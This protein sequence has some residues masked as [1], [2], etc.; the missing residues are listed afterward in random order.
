MKLRIIAAAVAMAGCIFTANA[1]E[2]LGNDIWMGVSGGALSTYTDHFNA[3]QMYFSI[4]AGKYFT[5]VW[6][7][8]IAVGGPF[9]MFD[10]NNKG[11][12]A[13]QNSKNWGKKQV[14]GELSLDGIVNL[15]QAFSKKSLPLVDFYL[16]AGPTATLS[17][18]CTQFTGARTADGTLIVEENNDLKARVGVTSGAGLGFN[19][20]KF[21]NLGLEYR[22]ALA[23]SVFG[24]ASRFR[25]AESTNRLTLRLAYTFGGRL[26]KEGFANKHGRVETVTVPVEKI[27]EKEVV[28]EIVKEVEKKVEVVSP[29]GNFVFFE[30]GKA[31]L[32][33]SDKVRLNELAKAISAGDRN[34]VYKVCGYADK[35]TGSAKTNQRLSEKRA[36]AVYDYLVSQGVDPA[37]LQVV[38]NGGVDNMFFNKAYLSRVAIVAM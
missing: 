31:N 19:L 7:G 2:K 9:Q 5:P 15:S 24:D 25:K 30:L 12:W 18:V 4:E 29:A 17:T 8:R 1:Q 33:D 20:S 16:F 11:S 27:V 13:V 22:Y 26:G 21:V 35:G 32:K 28:K 36:K 38:A 3:P 23:P 6:G 14:F 34:T 37:Q 10:A